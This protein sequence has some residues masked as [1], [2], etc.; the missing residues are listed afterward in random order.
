VWRDR[1]H[2]TA[3]HAAMVE[4]GFA[5][6]TTPRAVVHQARAALTLRAALRERFVWGRSFAG[7]RARLVGSPRRWVLAALTPLLPLVMTWRV[8]RTALER[9][10]HRQRLLETLPLII[11]L[12]AVWALGELVGYT[13]A[14]PG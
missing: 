14:H 11:L 3:V 13:T 6:Y 12:H 4:A 1:Y 5:L 10:H 7:T 8:T 2:E 9:G